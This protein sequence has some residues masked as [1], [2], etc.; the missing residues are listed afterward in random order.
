V[1]RSV[2][3]PPDRPFDLDSIPGAG[4][5]L[6]RVNNGQETA[7]RPAPQ[8]VAAVYFAPAEG[9]AA[10]FG[11]RDPMARLK[12]GAFADVRHQAVATRKN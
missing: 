6:A 11:D 2:A 8:R 4:T 1:A 9:F 7:S 10:R 12:T 3:L 5:P